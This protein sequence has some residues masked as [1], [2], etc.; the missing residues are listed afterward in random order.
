VACN[1][2]GFTDNQRQAVRL[3]LGLSPDHATLSQ[4]LSILRGLLIQ[5]ATTSH[6][7]I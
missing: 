1:S 4:A 6:H 7:I 3:S 2:F 5:P